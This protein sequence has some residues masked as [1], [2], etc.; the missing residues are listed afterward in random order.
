MET[1]DHEL[2]AQFQQVPAIKVL[3]ERIRSTRE[4]YDDFLVLKSKVPT[5]FF[6]ADCAEII[7]T[8]SFFGAGSRCQ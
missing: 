8:N 4:T 5:L 1:L 3:Q 2:R 7:P 6:S